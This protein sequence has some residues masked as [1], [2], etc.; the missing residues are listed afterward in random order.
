MSLREAILVANGSLTGTFTDAEKAQLLAAPSAARQTVGPSAAAA[1]AASTIRSRFPLSARSPHSALPDINDTA[2]LEITG[3]AYGL[4]S[5][6]VNGSA[7]SIGV[8]LLN[9][10]SHGNTLQQLNFA[11]SHGFGVRVAAATTSY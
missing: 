5:I 10:T 3:P 7:L 8:T 1:A 4:N 9:I 6:T 11:N 2:T